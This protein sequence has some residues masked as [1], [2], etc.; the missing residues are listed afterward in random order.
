[1]INE[2]QEA[3]EQNLYSTISWKKYNKNETKYI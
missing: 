2:M 1:M 3:K